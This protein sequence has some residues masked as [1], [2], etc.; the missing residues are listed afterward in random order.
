MVQSF[1]N[2]I[3]SFI[4]RDD[5]REYTIPEIMKGIKDKTREEVVATLARLEV[6]KKLTYRLRGRVKYYYSI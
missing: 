1:E 3:T 5:Q 6:K 2:K 4:K